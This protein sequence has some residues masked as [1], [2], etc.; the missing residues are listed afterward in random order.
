MHGQPEHSLISLSYSSAMAHFGRPGRTGLDFGITDR[1]RFTGWRN[2]PLRV[3]AGMDIFVL[4]SLFEP[5][6]IA[7]VEAMALGKPVVASAVGGISEIVPS[8]DF[9]ILVPSNDPQALARAIEELAVDADLRRTLGTAGK[10][11]VEEC[12]SLD[13]T[14]VRMER[15]YSR[16]TFKTL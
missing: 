5:F 11:R 12:Y 15:L 14:T 1:V 3:I 8:R 16:I 4:P 10:R 9:G 7:L 6:G 13:S 2:D